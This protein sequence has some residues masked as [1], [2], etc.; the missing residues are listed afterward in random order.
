[1]KTKNTIG[2]IL[3][4]SLLIAGG[5]AQAHDRSGDAL[6]GGLFGG[7]VGAVI[8][9]QVGGRDGAI[10]GGALGA[11]TG[12][13]ITTDHGHRERYVDAPVYAPVRERYVERYV[14]APVYVQPRPVVY[15]APEVR[16]VERRGHGYWGHREF[17][18]DHRGW[19]HRGGW[20]GDRHDDDDHDG[21]RWNYRGWD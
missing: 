5:G 7:G 9:N 11:A 16:Y 21:G 3:C 18:H 20:R 8:G 15:Y 2:L 1:M 13:A 4:S 14:A 12:V 19:D 6:L 17:H 10:I